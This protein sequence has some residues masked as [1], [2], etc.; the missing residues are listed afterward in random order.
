MLLLDEP[1]NDLDFAGLELLE[2]FLDRHRGGLVAVSHDRAFLERMTRIVEF[3]AETRRVR[4]YAGGWSAFEDER[5]RSQE[6]RD[7]A[8]RH[9]AT[10]RDRIQEQART[11]R[12]WEER[13]YGQGRK[14]KKSK[15]VGKRF[16]KKLGLLER[17]EKPWAPWRL[18]LELTPTRRAGDVVARL[19]QAVVEREGFRLG[20]I[21]LEI[22]NGDR[23]VV[24]G[25]NGAGKTTLLKALLGE[26]PL[27]DG[28]RWVGPGIVL[29]ELPQGKGLF[30][31]DRALLDLFLAA[32]GLDAGAARS[33]L[34]KFALGADDVSRPAHSLSPGERSRATLALLAARGVNTLVLDEPTNHLDLEAIEQLE[35]ALEQYDGTVVLVTHDRRFLDAFRATRTLEL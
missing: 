23:L 28:R 10:E 6:R 5:R 12:R 2:R 7:G 9:Y 35:S 32:S 25:R 3:E 18:E 1:T 22:R 11:M 8:Y 15:D 19:E 14:K 13:G 31:G 34:A 20:P 16:E 4:E 21:D 30:V 27:T 29:G 33:L 26:I 17:V 24:V